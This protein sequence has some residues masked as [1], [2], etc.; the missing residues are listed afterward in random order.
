M[1][2]K[3]RKESSS[4]ENDKRRL[5]LITEGRTNSILETTMAINRNFRLFH[6]RSILMGD[7]NGN[8]Q[9]FHGSARSETTLI[10]CHI[11]V[12]KR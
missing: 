6:G 4:K 8:S 10:T 3:D 2:N 12:K 9:S 11:F 7:S 1:A 5:T